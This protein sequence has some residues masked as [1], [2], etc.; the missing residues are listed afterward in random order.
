M[1]VKK[2]LSDSYPKIDAFC[3]VNSIED[4]LI[5]NNF[6]VVFEE[7]KYYGLLIPSDLIK[8]P[9]R[10]VVDCLTEKSKINS[11]DTILFA[12]D[13]LNENHSCALPVFENNQ[14]I[15]IVQKETIVS[16]LKRIMNELNEKSQ[17]SQ[18]VKAAFINGISHEIRTP[19][20][21]I[22]GFMNLLSDMD[23]DHL[24]KDYKEFTEIISENA[25]RFLLTMNDLIE[26]S[27]IHSG[28]NIRLR[29]EKVDIETLLKELK[30]FFQTKSQYRQKNLSF[31]YSVERGG[32][33][34]IQTDPKRLKHIFYHLIDNGSRLADSGSIISFGVE[35]TSGMGIHC[36]VRNT[37]TAI[38]QEDLQSV[39]SLFDK[40]HSGKSTSVG[41]GIGLTVVKDY[42]ESLCGCIELVTGINS[43]TFHFT[44]P[45]AAS[46]VPDL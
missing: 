11:D 17:V 6:L 9:K 1:L 40:G 32:Q 4:E 26:L 12:L 39:F 35:K 42:V 31:E 30:C 3:A 15:G 29:I 44:I 23:T 20:N 25:D 8:H 5:K 22:L 24:E 34:T 16:A 28:E 43:N 27:L 18:K 45:N 21:G 19:L 41:P 38:S 46:A 37:G 14:F 10:I 33:I 7:D 36:F 2:Y 13:Q